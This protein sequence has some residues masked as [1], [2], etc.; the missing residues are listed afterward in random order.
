MLSIYAPTK[1]HEQL[2]QII[3]KEERLDELVDIVNI[4]VAE[5]RPDSSSLI[6]ANGEIEFPIDWYNTQPP[7]LF[8]E[9]T[10]LNE[11][12]LLGIIFARLNNFEK[13]HEYLQ[14]ANPS[15]FLELDFMNRLQ[16]GMA[17]NPDELVSQYSPFEEYRLMHNQAIL[18]HYASAEEDFDLDKTI[19]F[20]GEALQAAPDDEYRAFTARHFAL[21]FIDLEQPEKAARILNIANH[22]RLSPVAH[23]EIRYALCQAWLQQLTVPYDLKLLSDLQKM[24]KVVVQEYEE[25]KRNISIAM[26]L[27]DA[28][29]VANYSESW[30][31]SLG[32]FN[33]AIAI[34]ESENLPELAANVQYRKGTLLFTWAKNGNPQ[35]YRPAAEAFQ[36]ASRVFSRESAPEQHADIQHHLGMIY[37]EFPDEEKKK[38]LWAGLSA[39]AFQEAL[40]IYRKE[41]FP[42][43]YAAVCNHYGNALTKYPEAKLSDNIAKAITF[44]QEA[45]QIRTAE[46]FPLERS[47]TL[48][49]YLEA[50]WHLNMPEDI[51]DEKRYLDM[52][53]KAN[54]V[55]TLNMDQKVIAEA[56]QHLKRLSQLKA[57]YSYS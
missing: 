32:Y 9:L 56:D 54:E 42:Y 53:E 18:R 11:A 12:N 14:K 26:V 5:P 33:R 1:Y 28:G 29:I 23:T 15:L 3:Q 41:Y 38:S 20:Y 21:L 55:K 7:F 47:L 8:P 51:F 45:L 40:G 25:Q 19:Y 48:L 39:T 43:E 35:F 49:N 27:T 22:L 34:F 4:L 36:L 6:I 24:L 10:P 37:A 46:R 16:L 52:V 57:A 30:S 31:E 44:Y 17:I 2:T 13:A 50:Q